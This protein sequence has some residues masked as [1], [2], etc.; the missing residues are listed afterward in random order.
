MKL[1]YIKV[2][3][4]R[5]YKDARIDFARDEHK[6]VTLVKGDNGAGKTT[7]TQA[8]RWC[9]YGD[10]GFDD[11]IIL[12]A[13]VIDELPED[14]GAESSVE[15]GLQFHDV[16]YRIIR[17]E[18][19]IKTSKGKVKLENK[20]ETER[21]KLEIY[22][23]E[24]KL[25]KLDAEIV[26]NEILPNEL[27]PYFFFDGERMEH[28]SRA[29][30]K[31]K[32]S[33]EIANVIRRV[34][35]LTSMDK[36]RYHLKNVGRKSVYKLLNEEITRNS[37]SE[38]Q[39]CSALLER[40][41]QELASIED[42]LKESRIMHEQAE[43]EMYEEISWLN[44]H[45][46]TAE[47]QKKQTELEEQRVE[48]LKQAKNKILQL[49]TCMS[50]D[51]ASGFLE[52]ILAE[53]ILRKKYWKKDKES[54]SDLEYTYLTVD[55]LD[56]ILEGK[57]CICGCEWAE[58]NE[59]YVFLKD[60]RDQMKKDKD[61]LEVKRFKRILENIRD[62]KDASFRSMQ[63]T[64]EEIDALYEKADE[65]ERSIE[66]LE[67]KM[68]GFQGDV[69]EHLKRKKQQSDIVQDTEQIIEKKIEEKA[70]IKATIDD[71][72]E[73]KNQYIEKDQTK[74][75][76]LVQLKMVEELHR[77][78]NAA[79][80]A[81]ETDIRADFEKRLQ[82][83]YDQIYEKGFSLQISDSY[84]I[85]EKNNRGL[86]EAQAYSIIIAFVCTVM[87]MAKNKKNIQEAYM[88]ESEE[89]PIVMDAP[90]SKFD[91]D[92]IENIS[93][94]LPNKADQVVIFIK[95]TDGNYAE[96]YMEERIGKRYEIKMNNG[97]KTD[98][99]IREVR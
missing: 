60:L 21:N 79:Y 25:N 29:L 39:E 51:I 64:M 72:R 45:V 34:V 37:T 68:D 67:E 82:A 26:L 33:D 90:L 32:T 43:Q 80:M 70:A 92:R 61:G 47:Y 50:K 8:F 58:D 54:N 27:S 84:V 55:L 1:V 78:I 3:N 48:H 9:L 13:D 53:E 49:N 46:S 56:E 73:K 12:N 52:K 14:K 10:V 11:D 89:Y 88:D 71:L 16:E 86:S 65:C 28:M 93:T 22:Q 81:K 98:S 7:F 18:K 59:H 42:T 36:L 44:R 15:I 40:K 31:E 6:N 17:S 96:Q 87:D 77:D 63:D 85:T 83:L 94:I 23:N 75:S 76:L 57:K 97:S 19:Y 66:D 5:Q 24:K 35:G 74:N 95:N 99:F 69:T 41:E 38:L 91:I 4:Y 2:K 20:L 62:V 30:M